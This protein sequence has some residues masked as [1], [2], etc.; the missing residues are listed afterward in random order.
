MVLQEAMSGS[1]VRITGFVGNRSLEGKL[2]QLG[3]MPGD[4]ARVLRI[5]PF[6]GPFLLE[7]SGREIAVSSNIASIIMVEVQA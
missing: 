7:V 6:D 5:A 4:L 2:R 1:I 3:L